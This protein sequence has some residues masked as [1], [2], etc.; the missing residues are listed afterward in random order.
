VLSVSKQ[1]ANKKPLRNQAKCNIHVGLVDTVMLC[2]CR[3]AAKAISSR[4]R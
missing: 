4:Q 1:V 2:Y 3:G